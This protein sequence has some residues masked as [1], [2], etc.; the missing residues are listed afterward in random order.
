MSLRPSMAPLI[1]RVRL[2]VGDPAGGE[3]TFSPEEIQDAL[4][5]ERSDVRYEELSYLE[6]YA[7]GAT[8][9]LDYQAC[10]GDWETDAVITDGSYN[11]VTPDTQDWSIGRFTF[12]ASRT[13]PLYITGRRYDVNAAAIEVA[14]A[15]LAKIKDQFDF[16]TESDSFNL[17]QKTQHLQGVIAALEAQS[18]AG[19]LDGERGDW[20]GTRSYS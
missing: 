18:P 19:V 20:I 8:S 16:S 6:T 4:D 10:D 1:E 7:P 3:E 13:P 12:V 9:Y 2:L 15:W 5:R 14:R 11:T 17:D